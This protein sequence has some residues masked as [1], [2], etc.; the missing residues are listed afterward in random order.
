M[1][2]ECKLDADGWSLYSTMPKAGRAAKKLSRKLTKLVNEAKE[3]I[4][5]EPLLNR[6]AVA[7]I[8]VVDPFYEEMCKLSRFGAADTEPRNIMLVEVERAFDL[9][10]YTLEV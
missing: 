9:D 4:A 2:Y 10:D 1:S 6:E 8:A 3:R 7:Q 5:N